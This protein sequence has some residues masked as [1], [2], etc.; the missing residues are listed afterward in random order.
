[1]ASKEV[2][3][4]EDFMNFSAFKTNNTVLIAFNMWIC[5]YM[6][7]ND[8]DNVVKENCN[9][10]INLFLWVKVRHSKY[11]LREQF[12]QFLISLAELD[13]EKF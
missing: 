8:G 1:M 4:I 5:L 6:G 10:I 2:G 3:S 12:H 13:T 9:V 11:E 7:L